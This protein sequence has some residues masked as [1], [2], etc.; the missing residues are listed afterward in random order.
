MNA[1]QPAVYAAQIVADSG[2]RVVGRTRFQK[3]TYLLV[4]AGLEE[5]FS[6]SY[7]HYGPYSED[8]AT[9]A[10]LAKFFGCMREEEHPTSWGGNYSV[11]DV[12]VPRQTGASEARRQ[13]AAQAAAADAVELEL[14]ATA[15]FLF[16]EG[17]SE[18]WAE[19][20]RRKPEKAEG[21]RINRAMAL[22]DNLRAV[23][24]PIPLPRVT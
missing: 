17:F 8:L 20:A 21:G 16:K 10:K 13:L 5:N 12:S 4:A 1:P 23:S 11:F 18:A 6:F 2:G 14:A 19:T 24:T 9:A 15:L 22:Y 7:K 3:I